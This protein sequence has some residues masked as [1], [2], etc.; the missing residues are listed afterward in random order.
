MFNYPLT[1][2]EIFLFL[3]QKYRQQEFELALRYMVASQSVI[4]L[5]IAI[6]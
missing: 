5:I 4:I 2:A 6:A 1:R 3:N